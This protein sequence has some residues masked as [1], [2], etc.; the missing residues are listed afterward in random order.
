MTDTVASARAWK[1]VHTH[2]LRG[3][4]EVVTGLRVGGSQDTMQISGLDNPILR[5][6]ANDEPYMPGSSL[7]GKMRM[8]AD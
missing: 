7:K 6:P 3:Q 4:I 2:I 1:L 8:L 5:D